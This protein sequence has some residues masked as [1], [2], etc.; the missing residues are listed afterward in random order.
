MCAVALRYNLE[1]SMVIRWINKQTSIIDDA[2]TFSGV[3]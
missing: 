2:E 1:H 3:S